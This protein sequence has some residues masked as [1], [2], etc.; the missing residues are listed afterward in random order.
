[1]KKAITVLLLIIIVISS[2]GFDVSAAY[3]DRSDYRNHDK[4]FKNSIIVDGVDVSVYQDDDIDW[5]AAKSSGID[6]AIMRVTLTRNISGSLETDDMFAE[7]YKKAKKAGLMCGVY[8]FSQAVNAED[9]A[10]EA[11]FAVSRLRKLGIGP[12]DL[13]LPVYMD[14]E[15][16]NKGGSRLM[17]LTE[18]DAIAAAKSF[19]KTVRSYGYDAGIYANSYFFARYLNNGRDFADNIDLWI[20]QYSN[21]ISSECRYT[22]WQYSSSA[23]ISDIN[24]NT[25]SSGKIDINY[26]YIDRRVEEPTINISGSTNAEYTGKPVLPELKVHDRGKQLKE[27]KDYIIGGIRNTDAGSESYAYIKGIGNYEGYALV[28][29]N[30]TK[31]PFDRINLPSKVITDTNFKSTGYIIYS[32]TGRTNIGII[33][34]GTTVGEL[35]SDIQLSSDDYYTGIIDSEGNI[36]E[37]EE[38]VIFSDMIGVYR[39]D[40]DTLIGTIDIETETEKGIN[41]LKRK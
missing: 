26:W 25:E 21:S 38:T 19:C 34:E 16:Y 31:E 28:P 24:T 5:N 14:Y 1:M 27:G 4:R 12:D 33:P 41:H 32:D 13:M 11:E 3:E 7:Y 20:A 29:I 37:D 35:L 2:A 23:R 18:E 15:F 6:F 40:D 39:C 9:G 10:R 30:I 36:L 17:G 8:V 22:K